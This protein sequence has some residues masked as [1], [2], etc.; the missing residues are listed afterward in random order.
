M[1]PEGRTVLFVSHNMSAV[2]KLCSRALLI[3]GGEVA[4]SG[5]TDDVIKKYMEKS[6]QTSIARWENLIKAPGNEFVGF[7]Y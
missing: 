2:S 7:R 4:C 3:D 6:T 1:S 5:F